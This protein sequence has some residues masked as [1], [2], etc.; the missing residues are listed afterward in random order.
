MNITDID[1]KTIYGSEQAGLPLK[2]FTEKYIEDFMQD[3]DTL[4]VL[5]ATVYPRASEHVEDMILMTETLLEKGHAYEKHHSVYFDLS[6][7]W[8]VTRPLTSWRF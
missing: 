7:I 3:I 8:I 4:G 5:R 6:K 2:Y 1:D